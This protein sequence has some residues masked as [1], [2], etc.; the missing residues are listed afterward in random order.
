[1]QEKEMSIQK[2]E[3]KNAPKKY[4]N[5]PKKMQKSAQIIGIFGP[6]LVFFIQK[7]PQKNTKSSPKRYKILLKKSKNLPKIICLLRSN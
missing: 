4:K 6:D 5:G 1:M 3:T 7:S 2:G